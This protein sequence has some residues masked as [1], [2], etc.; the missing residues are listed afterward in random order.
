MV[1]RQ[2]W[3]ARRFEIFESA[4]HFRIESNRIWTSDSNSNR[5]WKLRIAGPYQKA[6]YA[7]CTLS[8]YFQRSLRYIGDVKARNG[9]KF[10]FFSNFWPILWNPLTKVDGSMPECVQV[11][12]QHMRPHLTLLRETETVDGSV[13]LGGIRK[14]GITSQFLAHPVETRERLVHTDAT[15]GQRS[16]KPFLHTLLT[17]LYF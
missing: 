10:D 4:R 6:T 7:A 13:A 5:I 2:T 16:D 14:T 1:R 11:C 8:L 15:V 12:A 9:P 3:Q 17:C